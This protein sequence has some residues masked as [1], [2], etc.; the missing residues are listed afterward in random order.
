MS[1]PQEQTNDAE[2]QSATNQELYRLLASAR[3]ALTDDMV[4]RLSATA[5]RWRRPPGPH[6]SQRRG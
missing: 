4:T 3:D 1:Q 2:E 6:Q 5:S